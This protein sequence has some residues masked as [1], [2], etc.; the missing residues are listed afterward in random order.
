MKRFITFV[1]FTLFLY[2]AVSAQ[3]MR[4]LNV[5]V[6]LKED[7]SSNLNISYRFTEEIKKIDFPFRGKISD[8][9]FEKGKCEVKKD[10]ENIL[11][12]EPPSP[13]MVGDITLF[14]WFKGTGLV[15]RQGNTTHF[16]FDIPILWKTDRIFVTVKLPDGMFLS[17]RVLLPI[18]PSGAEKKIE[19]KNIITSW[20][21][22]N[23][24]P[25]DVIPIRIYYESI[26]PQPQIE[27]FDYRWLFAPIFILIIGLIIIYKKLP[28]KTELVLSVLNEGERM[29]VDI[30][31]KEGKERVDQRKIVSSSGF[32]KAKVSRIIHSLQSRGVVDV[33]RVGRKNRVSLRKMMLKE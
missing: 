11:H 31:R 30:I 27:Y 2:P 9:N 24:N 3:I 29:I 13:F 4:Q 5:S 12:C 8:L 19:G 32:S 16:S 21:F 15:E 25:G 26:F 7:S 6:D 33:E 17:D 14:V 10:T 23:K 1:I 22:A 18:S 20:S 28:K